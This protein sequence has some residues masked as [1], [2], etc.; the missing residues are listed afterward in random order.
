MRTCRRC[1]GLCDPGDL[2]GDKCTD[3]IEE[4]R[5]EEERREMTRQMLRRNLA[6]QVDG[7]LVMI[8]NR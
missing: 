8:C 5:L 2:V 1:G 6:E 7:Q 4:E 3:C